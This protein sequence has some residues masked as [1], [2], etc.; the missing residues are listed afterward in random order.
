MNLRFV[1][2]RVCV[3]STVNLRF[4]L[5]RVC[6][7]LYSLGHRSS[8]ITSNDHFVMFVCV[9]DCCINAYSVIFV[10]QVCACMHYY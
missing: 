5:S 3:F 2:S 9:Y 8:N 10:I 7:F 6:V 1:L 4:V